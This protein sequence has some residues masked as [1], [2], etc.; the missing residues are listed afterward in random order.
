MYDDRKEYYDFVAENNFTLFF[1][2]YSYDKYPEQVLNQELDWQHI[3]DTY[4]RDKVVVVDNFLRADI[5]QRLRN[6]ILYLNVRQDKYRDYAAVN[7]YRRTDSLW[8]PLLTNIVDECKD[9]FSFLEGHE[10][11]RAWSFIYDNESEGVRPHADP[12]AVNFNLWVT[13]DN[14]VL[15]PDEQNGLD[16]WKVYPP[17]DWAWE[18]Y[19][20]DDV[21]IAEF[22]S[23]Y[24]TEKLA[25]PYRFNRVTI[26]NSKFFHKTQPVLTKPG[27]GNRRINYT[28]L[29]G[30]E[31]NGGL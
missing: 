29:F 17:A 7:F 6:Y 2:P 25:I 8:F 3:A 31:Q 28:F 5:A 24:G 1:E 12:A 23:N 16:V 11:I 13:D 9:R 27:Y 22:L 30:E 19:N 20:G 10:F 18:T 15:N 21:A 4:K 26:F 14:C